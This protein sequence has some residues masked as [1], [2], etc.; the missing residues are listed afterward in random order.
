MMTTKDECA[1]CG[2]ERNLL[3]PKASLFPIKKG[4]CL[5]C[6]ICIR[7]SLWNEHRDCCGEMPPDKLLPHLVEQ[8]VRQQMEYAV[9][10]M[11][12]EVEQFL[13]YGEGE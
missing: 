5:L 11:R 7:E 1:L 6:Y 10:A 4:I 8:D 12:N 13:L 9:P 3:Y 2:L